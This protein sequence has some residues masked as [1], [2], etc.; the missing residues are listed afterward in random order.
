MLEARSPNRSVLRDA[1]RIARAC[2]PPARPWELHATTTLGVSLGWRSDPQ[3]ALAMLTDARVMAEELG[4]L[5]ELFR[6]HANLTTVLELAGRHEEAV[7]VATAG[8]A[9]AKDAGLE[10]GLRQHPARQRR[11]LP[12]PPRALGGGTGDEHDRPGVAPGRRELPR[13]ARVARDGR[14]RA[15]RGRGGGPLARPDTA[16][17]RGRARR[18][19]GGPLHLAAASFALWRGDLADA[20]RAAER[21]WTLVRETEDWVLAARTAAAAIEVEA[22][23]AVEARDQRDLPSW[24]PRANVLAR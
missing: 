2:D 10:A 22:A 17:T 7:E 12:V 11:R 19:A 18:P 15:V 14:H 23:T 20:R 16:R 21:G 3:A 24:R 5:D 6:V 13:R 4:D 9:V 8:I 1:I